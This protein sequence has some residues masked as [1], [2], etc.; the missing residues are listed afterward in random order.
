MKLL[1]I[2]PSSHTKYPSPPLGLLQLAACVEEAGHE[3]KI[4]DMNLK[5]IFSLDWA[6]VIG[7]TAVTPNVN[8]AI[9]IARIIKLGKR[10]EQTIILGGPHATILPEETLK[11]GAFDIVVAGE[12]DIVFPELINQMANNSRYGIDDIPNL[13]CKTGEYLWETIQEDVT[14]D[15]NKLPM[16][17]YS[18][19]DLSRYHPHPPHGRKK[20]WLPMITSR[21]CPY[22]CAFCSKP[23]FGSE[24]RALSAENVWLQLQSME[25]DGIRE[26]TFYDDV[27]TL[28]TQ[29]VID[30]CDGMMQRELNIDWSCETRTHLVSP[31]LLYSMEKAGC[32]LI[33]YGIESGSQPILNSLNKGINLEQV[34]QAIA[35]TRE[36]HIQT[37]GYFMIGNPGETKEDIDKTIQFAIDLKLDYAQFAITT[38]LPGSQLYEQYLVSS[39]QMPNWDAFQ[40]ANMGK[41]TIPMFNGQ[42]LST[43]DIRKALSDANKRFYLRLG[44]IWHRGLVAIKSWDDFKLLANGA[45]V[46][47]E[48]MI[49]K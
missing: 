36:Q 32:F 45:K 41:A 3:V 11:A 39:H 9:R 48:N 14:C 4:A 18:L 31:R 1:L 38:P 7:I 17:D 46:Y 28:E 15:L 10:K 5:P 34:A 42:N 44:Y 20:P 49:G 12:G 21:G 25:A 13:Y 33:A 23:V 6:D 37:I 19:I 8:E 16:P 35:Y 47:L 43:D 29:R 30:I 26:V 22:G 24:Y 2:N 40:Y 27:F